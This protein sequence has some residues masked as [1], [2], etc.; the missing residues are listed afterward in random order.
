LTSRFE[1]SSH[2]S[3]SFHHARTRPRELS[4]LTAVDLVLLIVLGDA[5]QQGLTEDDYWVTGAIIAV[6]RIGVVQVASSYITFPSK[7]ARKVIDG[8]PIVL[9]EHAKLLDRTWS[10]NS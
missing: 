3:S 5:I 9:I 10:G 8:Q 2:T 4:T 1:P 6:S 7:R